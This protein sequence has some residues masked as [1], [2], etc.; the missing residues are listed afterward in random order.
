V[1]LVSLP[2]ARLMTVDPPT[3]PRFVGGAHRRL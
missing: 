1:R 3:T 2:E